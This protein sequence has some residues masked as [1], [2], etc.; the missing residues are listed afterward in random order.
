MTEP[1]TLSVSKQTVSP[2]PQSPLEAKNRSSVTGF[3]R[4]S[5]NPSIL[6]FGSSESS[7]SGMFAG[8]KTAASNT[9]TNSQ[10][11][12]DPTF[13]ENGRI[14]RSMNGLREVV[15][16][17]RQTLNEIIELLTRGL[18]TMKAKELSE[19][20]ST[21][22][23][24]GVDSLQASCQPQSGELPFQEKIRQFLSPDANASISEARLQYGIMAFQLY[25][26]SP[27]IEAAFQVAFAEATRDGLSTAEASKQA[28]RTVRD[29]GMIEA[30]EADWAF[31]VSYRASQLDSSLNALSDTS[32]PTQNFDAATFTAEVALAYIQGG[33]IDVPT[34]SLG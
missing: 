24:A 27:S 34:R 31:S 10:M 19:V 12:L 29:D 9:A 17:L 30:W 4:P 16:L 20:D 15:A 32:S 1:A 28:L 26:K 5:R 7:L 2:M 8:D 18:T 21:G 11:S 13:A 3:A 6:P 22:G 23:S 33:T 25:Q 14:G